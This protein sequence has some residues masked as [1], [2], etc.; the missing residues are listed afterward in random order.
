MGLI[1][2][3]NKIPVDI[4]RLIILYTNKN[5]EISNYT[6]KYCLLCNNKY[7]TEKSWFFVN[8]TPSK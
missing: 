3:W 8:T 4:L 1:T 2:D 6:I 7:V 5:E